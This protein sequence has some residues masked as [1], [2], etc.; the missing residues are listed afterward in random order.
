MASDL[1][2]QRHNRSEICDAPAIGSGDGEV[3][4]AAHNGEYDRIHPLEV[5]DDAVQT[6]SESG[7]FQFFGCRCPFHINAESMA[8]ERLHQVEG[9]ATEEENEHGSP[10]DG[11]P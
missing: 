6:D 3:Y 8:N 9:D 4:H 5:S 1:I 11:L 10:F 2:R 7:G